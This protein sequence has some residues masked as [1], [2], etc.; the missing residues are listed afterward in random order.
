MTNV[1]A[2]DYLLNAKNYCSLNLPTYFDLDYLIK[3]AT[4][5]LR[6]SQFYE[7]THLVQEKNTQ[8]FWASIILY[9]IYLI[10]DNHIS[11]HT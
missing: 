8:I 7:K 10:K 3:S 2:C 9:C 1:E 5:K 4:N 6:T 11:V